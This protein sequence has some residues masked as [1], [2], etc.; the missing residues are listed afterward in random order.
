MRKRTQIIGLIVALQLASLWPM[1]VRAATIDVVLP[2]NAAPR[3]EFGAEELAAALNAVN[4]NAVIVHTE[5]V[6]SE[7]IYLNQPPDSS[8]GPEGFR[9]NL[10][11]NNDLMILSRDNSGVL[12]GCLELARRIRAD[13]K[14]PTAEIANF[15]DAPAMKLRGTC[16]GL[17]KTYILPGRHVYE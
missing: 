11:Q 7:K 6:G 9:F 17:Q 5:N 13:G 10:M 3:V 15:R 2:T 1:A 12:Y 8:I 16:I 14:L 4:L